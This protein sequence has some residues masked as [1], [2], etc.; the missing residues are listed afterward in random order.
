MNQKNSATVLRP[1]S[2]SLTGS[3]R[4]VPLRPTTRFS[5]HESPVKTQPK[6]FQ[7][8]EQSSKSRQQRIANSARVSQERGSFSPDKVTTART[9][10][11][12]SA[13][14]NDN[15]SA[16]KAT[17]SSSRNNSSAVGSKKEFLLDKARFIT[18]PSQMKPTSPSEFDRTAGRFQL[19]SNQTSFD[20]SQYGL[21]SSTKTSQ[22]PAGLVT[23]PQAQEEAMS[24]KN[25]L[26]RKG[27]S[28]YGK[29]PQS[30]SNDKLE[31][32]SVTASTDYS[33]TPKVPAEGD[34]Q[35]GR[36][37]NVPGINMKSMK[38]SKE[39]A[40]RSAPTSIDRYEFYA[41]NFSLG[42]SSKKSTQRPEPIDSKITITITEAS[43]T[44]TPYAEVPGNSLLGQFFNSPSQHS[45]S[46]G[47]PNAMIS[48]KLSPLG[49]LLNK[50]S[51]KTYLES[52]SEEKKENHINSAYLLPKNFE[53]PVKQHRHTNSMINF[54]KPEEEKAELSDR[55][56]SGERERVSSKDRNV[57]VQPGSHNYGKYG[58]IYKGIENRDSWRFNMDRFKKLERQCGTKLPTERNYE[59]RKNSEQERVN[60]KREMIPSRGDVTNYSLSRQRGGIETDRDHNQSLFSKNEQS[61]SRYVEDIRREEE[62]DTLGGAL[63][64][65]SDLKSRGLL[66]WLK[67]N[68]NSLKLYQE[69]E[70]MRKEIESINSN[71]D[72]PA[73]NLRREELEGK[74]LILLDL[75]VNNLTAIMGK[76]NKH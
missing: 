61:M 33:K 67:S 59:T 71:A 6:G 72:H 57:L 49:M 27:S 11:T 51:L 46:L 18:S 76:K 36:R 45:S 50:N 43:K 16:R 23:S 28:G 69:L 14:K 37:S 8:P 7:S 1:S 39:D 35:E 17:T 65:L 74:L 31:T 47:M 41:D 58:K 64:Y 62:K 30:V 9:G 29:S 70:A 4:P 66:D 10:L 32:E 5:A 53:K 42:N 19:E 40:Y 12:N 38:K 48:P 54:K 34:K 15:T 26:L 60:I 56:G 25:H 52:E 22:G 63:A 68:K 55:S 20:L 2:S 3:S 44:N 21:G 13:N 73:Y 75:T 24:H